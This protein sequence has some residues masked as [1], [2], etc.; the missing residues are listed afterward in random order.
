MC[1][2]VRACVSCNIDV[3]RWPTGWVRRCCCYRP[4]AAACGCRNVISSTGASAER[5][6]HCSVRRRMACTLPA[7][8]RKGRA[9]QLKT[10]HGARAATD[11]RMLMRAL[12]TNGAA[13]AALR[14]GAHRSSGAV[15]R[16]ALRTT[17]RRRSARSARQ[18]ETTTESA[19]GVIV[20]P[21][22]PR[23]RLLGRAALGLWPGRP[24]T[25]RRASAAPRR[26]HPAPLQGAR[27]Q[28]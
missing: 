22:P 2:D 3:V 11:G 15:S 26:S 23:T 13:A 4:P 19:P 10:R 6:P 12:T 17:T 14:A 21:A 25:R 28:R 5:A 27:K 18:L 7:Q 8:R 16:T 1:I 20:S 24:R 9:P